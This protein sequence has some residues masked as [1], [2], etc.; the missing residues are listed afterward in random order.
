MTIILISCCWFVNMQMATTTTTPPPQPKN[1]FLL[2]ETKNLERWFCL[3]T[4]NSHAPSRNGAITHDSQS[5]AVFNEIYVIMRSKAL[6]VVC[7]SYYHRHHVLVCWKT[8]SRVI[9]GLDCFKQTFRSE[10][11][12]WKDELHMIIYISYSAHSLL[13]LTIDIYRFLPRFPLTITSNP[14]C[15]LSFLE[16]TLEPGE[17]RHLLY[18]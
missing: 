17:S 6:T 3:V 1:N 8:A 10:T 11:N 4:W 7:V 18:G 13:S 2:I 15:Q 12:L 16:E 14:P 9:C 5:W